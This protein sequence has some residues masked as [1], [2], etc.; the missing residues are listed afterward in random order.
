MEKNLP[1]RSRH[2]EIRVAWLRAH[3]KSGK[4]KLKWLCGEL[5]PCRYV[6]GKRVNEA[7]YSDHR[8]RLGFIVQDGHRS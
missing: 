4:L 5:K 6:H 1:R 3:L 8:T 2:I 7:L